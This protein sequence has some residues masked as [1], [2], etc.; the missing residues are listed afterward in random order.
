MDKEKRI[1]GEGYLKRW[2][3]L[4]YEIENLQ[5]EINNLRKNTKLFEEID[6]NDKD[7]IQKFN[8]L[9]INEKMKKLKNFMY[10]YKE[11][12]SI[13]N[14]LDNY[15]KDVIKFRYVHKNSWQMVAMKSHISIR[16]CFNI[17][18]F[19]IEQILQEI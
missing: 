17:K 15:K 9:F 7:D 13:L 3:Q 8:D 6:S 16:Q 14:Q 5:K 18:N 1:K 4:M 10:E 2:G 19:V 11:I 12:D